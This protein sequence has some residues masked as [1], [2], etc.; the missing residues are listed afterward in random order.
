MKRELVNKSWISCTPL[1]AVLRLASPRNE[2]LSSM[3]RTL[4]V[5][6]LLLRVRTEE[7]DFKNVFLPP[8]VRLHSR[9]TVALL[10]RSCNSFMAFRA[11]VLET[12][13]GISQQTVD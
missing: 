1:P 7:I 6:Q 2:N 13:C 5:D 4:R 8:D 10:G 12:L 9:S 11:A 3:G